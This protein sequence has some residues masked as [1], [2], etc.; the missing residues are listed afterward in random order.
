MEEKLKAIFIKVLG[1]YDLKKKQGEYEKWDS[2][3]HMDLVSEIE[4]QFNIVLNSDDVI[5]IESA[6]QALRIIKAKNE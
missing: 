4:S 5:S 3:S 2:F 6:E 1:D